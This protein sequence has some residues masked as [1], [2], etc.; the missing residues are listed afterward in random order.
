[1]KERYTAIIKTLPFLVAMAIGTHQSG[2]AQSGPAAPLDHL[3]A[4]V[5]VGPVVEQA[6][7]GAAPNATCSGAVVNP[8]SVGTPVSVN[9]DNTGAALDPV[10][11]V[12]V[13]W[14]AFTTMECAD[15]AV[16]YC[17]TTPAF[18]GALIT[19]AV[20]CPLT[21]FVFNTPGNIDGDDCGDGNYTILFPNLPAGTYYYPVQQGAGSTGPYT[22]TFTATACTATPPVNAVCAGA[23]PLPSA[24]ECTPV[25]G[26]V[27]FATAAGNTG[28]GCGNGDVADGVWYSF[29]ATS[30]A[31]E[32]TVAP[33]AQFNAHV[34]VFS[35]ACG[36]LTSIACAIGSNFGVQTV[37]ELTGLTIGDTYYIRVSDWYSGS[38]VTTGFFVCL[39]TI[40]TIECEESAGTLTTSAA[41]VCLIDGQATISATPN[42]DAVVPEGFS[43]LYLLTSGVDQVIVQGAFTPSF[44]VTAA[45]SYTIHTLVYDDTTLDLN[46]L[47]FGSTTAASVNAQLVQG[48][49]LVCAGLD[50]VGA[51]TVVDECL[52]C[53][54][55][56]GGLDANSSTIC[57]L[58]TA[59]LDA[60]ADGTM[61]VPDGF[62]VLYLLTTAQDLVIRQGALT[63]AFVV[64]SIGQYIIHTL[65]YDP[66]TLD[67]GQVTLGVTPATEVNAQLLQGGGTVCAALDLT[68]APVTVE[69]CNSINERGAASWSIY[70]NPNNGRFQVEVAGMESPV[71]LQVI[72]AD[73]RLVAE[74]RT[75][76]QTNTMVAMELPAN[77]GKGIYLLR[78]LAQ[79]E[80]STMRI[81]VE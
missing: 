17:G 45:G 75:A 32:L 41:S 15:I 13:V 79:G 43:M 12:P 74:Q 61:I 28:I 21:N 34:Q 36:S 22:I 46:G 25:S 31:Y 62:E 58:G 76:V 29:E 67:L 10:F 18:T 48:G 59:T 42:G 38:P 65:V 73:G 81:V 53:A 8:L 7:G 57:L 35:G 56:A 71:T 19:L 5:G 30:S 63:P 51:T 52:P 80:V 6:Q 2:I 69:I 78:A 9:G 54:A 33:S 66:A 39:E 47:V 72:S 4:G 27:A 44:I 26:N 55:N 11:G 23:I 24:A 49:G 68:G 14:E 60:T 37:A 1:M 77:T 3:Q 40:F 16:A 20:G 70:P 64:N 50:L